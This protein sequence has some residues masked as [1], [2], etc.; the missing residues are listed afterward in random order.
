MPITRLSLRDVNFSAS[1][2]VSGSSRTVQD[3]TTTTKNM[4]MRL[5]NGVVDASVLENGCSYSD[6]GLP[7]HLDRFQAMDILRQNQ[8]NIERIKS[9]LE[10]QNQPPEPADPKPPKAESVPPSEP[11]S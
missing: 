2:D 3:L 1:C 10:A 5:A 8:A 7:A 4:V 9:D 6:L 11:A